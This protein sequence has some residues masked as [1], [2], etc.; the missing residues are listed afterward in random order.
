MKRLLGR[1]LILCLMPFLFVASALAAETYTIDPA[2]TAVV[3]HISHFGFSNPS[4]KW[5]VASGTLTL[6]EAKPQDSKVDVIIKIADIDTGIPDL[7]RHLKSE[8]FFDVKKY[9]EATF[10]SNKVV[11]TGKKTAKVT[12]I[13]TL[14]GVSKPVTLNVTLNKIG[15]NFHN[16]KAVGF[17]ATTQLKRSD[18]GM[19]KLLP[20]LGDE[21]KIEI[22]AEAMKS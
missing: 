20:G 18:F 4:G 7:D 9:A 10:V 21:V 12:G 11:V 3:W 5:M 2:H 17:T 8:E 13:L 19:N 15:M 6:D 14:H 16:K 22:E 1:L